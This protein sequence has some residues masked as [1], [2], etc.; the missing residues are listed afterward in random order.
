MYIAPFKNIMNEFY[1][2]DTSK[3]IKVANRIIAENGGHKT[4]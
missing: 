3:K 1:A 4:V 2:K